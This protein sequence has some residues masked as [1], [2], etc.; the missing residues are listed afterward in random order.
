MLIFLF[1]KL[2]IG[3]RDPR[4]MVHLPAGPRLRH[5][6]CDFTTKLCL[7]C[8]K[9]SKTCHTEPKIPR[10]KESGLMVQNFIKLLLDL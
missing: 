5:L 6:F 7:R 8:K 9:I 3:S 1:S 10:C 4:F 2:P